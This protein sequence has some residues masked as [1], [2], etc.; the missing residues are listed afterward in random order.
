[1]I[2]QNIKEFGGKLQK[3]RSEN[4]FNLSRRRRRKRY[5]VEET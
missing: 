5:F 4:R 1:M 2:Q 3:L